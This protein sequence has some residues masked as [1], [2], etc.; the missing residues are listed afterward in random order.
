MIILTCK[1]YN[2]Q[3]RIKYHKKCQEWDYKQGGFPQILFYLFPREYGFV[4]ITGNTH[5]WRK[6][7]KELQEINI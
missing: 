1:E 3:Q 7:K 6:T 4:G 2:K 5:Y